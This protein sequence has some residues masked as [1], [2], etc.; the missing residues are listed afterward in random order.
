M[1]QWGPITLGEWA[2]GWGWVCM[3]LG[4]GCTRQEFSVHARQWGRLTM[5]HPPSMMKA[6]NSGSCG[7]A[8]GDMWRCATRSAPQTSRIGHVLRDNAYIL[9]SSRRKRQDFTQHMR[10]LSESDLEMP[11]P[12]ISGLEP[13]NF[14][15]QEVLSTNVMPLL[16][17]SGPLPKLILVRL[18]LNF[19]LVQISGTPFCQWSTSRVVQ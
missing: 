7:N 1:G 14:D 11:S 6:G 8:S 10:P 12:L 13:C 4:W 3:Q 17:G 19:L 16:P 2:V 18:M 15:I 9:D 5:A